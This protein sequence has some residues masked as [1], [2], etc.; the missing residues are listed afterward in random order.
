MEVIIGMTTIMQMEQET[1]DIYILICIG[2]LL[3]GC[4][5]N[6]P[7]GS[8]G[9][10]LNFLQQHQETILLEENNGKS[11]LIVLP[12]LQGRVMTSTADGLEG[13]SYGWVNYDLIA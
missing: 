13:Q 10:D 9:Y 3:T 4:S 6:L 12:E 2:I 1:I 8:F 11:Q 5:S 7:K